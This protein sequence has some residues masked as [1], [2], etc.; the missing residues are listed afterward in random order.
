MAASLK[1]F[2]PSRLLIPPK[3]HLGLSNSPPYHFPAPSKPF[4]NPNLAAKF[5][6][7]SPIN[8]VTEEREIAEQ[9]GDNQDE[10]ASSISSTMEEIK[11]FTTSDRLLNAAIVLGAG[12][13]AITKLLTIDHDYWQV[14]LIIAPFC[15]N[16]LVDFFSCEFLIDSSLVRWWWL[17]LCQF[18]LVSICRDGLCM[19]CWGMRLSITGL[20][21]KKLSRRTRCWLKWR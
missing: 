10:E 2:S 12:S 4:L 21:M 19:R 15:S 17:I 11:E 1:S 16:F 18:L 7:L 3:K 14:S 9:G 6:P 20:H 5:R 13:F 8:A